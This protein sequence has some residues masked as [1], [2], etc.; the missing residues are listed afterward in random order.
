M[1][2]STH[3]YTAAVVI[4]MD[5]DRI[6]IN[7]CPKGEGNNGPNHF[8]DTARCKKDTTEVRGLLCTHLSIGVG[9]YPIYFKEQA[10]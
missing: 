9:Y 4:E 1:I 5:F 8:V 3:R 2:I 7:Q 10:S 6:D